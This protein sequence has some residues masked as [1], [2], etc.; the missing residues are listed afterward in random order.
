LH[1]PGKTNV[2]ADAL[3][4]KQR[5]I[6]SVNLDNDKLLEEAI[7]KTTPPEILSTQIHY[8]SNL[9]IKPVHVENLFIEYTQDPEFSEQYKEPEN[10]YHIHNGILCAKTTKFAC[11]RQTFVF[12]SSTKTMTPQPLDS[13]ESRNPRKTFGIL[14]LDCHEIN[15]ETIH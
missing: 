4:K 14:P 2:V 1:L 13:L 11:Q 8:V 10:P 15:S 6:P 5:E 12:L 9:H 7:R 3:S